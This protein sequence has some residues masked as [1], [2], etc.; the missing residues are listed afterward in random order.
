TSKRAWFAPKKVPTSARRCAPT[1][2]RP[3]PSFV[4]EARFWKSWCGR[5]TWWWWVPNTS[6]KQVWFISSTGLHGPRGHQ[7]KRRGLTDRRAA[8]S[9]RKYK[10]AFVLRVAHLRRSNLQNNGWYTNHAAADGVEWQTDARPAS[11]RR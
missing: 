1:C 3:P 11:N 7:T 2:V 10:R 4:T 9:F 8:L 5:G 6:W